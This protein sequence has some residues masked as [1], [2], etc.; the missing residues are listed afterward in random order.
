MK[1][2]IIIVIFAIFIIYICVLPNIFN[3]HMDNILPQSEATYQIISSLVEEKITPMTK[4]IYS[5][6]DEISLPSSLSGDMG[7]I[8]RDYVCYRGLAND[9]NFMARRNGCVA[10]QV[11]LSDN[12]NRTGTNVIATCVYGSDKENKLNR[13]IW[14]RQMCN[15]QCASM[16]DIGK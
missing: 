2:K 8:G 9:N 12:I 10:C 4:S 11:D 6:G 5:K 7:Y 16:P 1:E 13:L 14:T 15:D 3:E